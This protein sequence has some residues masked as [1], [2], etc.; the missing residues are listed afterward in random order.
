MD[1]RLP[2]KVTELI[3]QALEQEATDLFLVP[4]EPP[5]MRIDGQLQ[6]ANTPALGADEVKEMAADIL[7]EEEL[8]RIGPEL[9]E[10]HRSF[11]LPG[12]RNALF[13]VARSGGN[14]SIVVRLVAYELPTV[15]QIKLPEA[16]LEAASAR[17]GL[18]LF[19]GPVGSGKTTTMLSVL[20]HINA[21]RQ[22]HICT[23]ED[24][25]FMRLRSKQAIIQQREVGQDVPTCL[26]GIHAAMQQ[27]LDVLMVGEL[28]TVEELTACISVAETGSLVLSQLH[29]GT[30]AAAIERVMD[31]FPPDLWEISRKALARSLRAVCAQRLLPRADSQGRV[32]AYDVLVPDQVIRDAIASGRPILSDEAP[33]P[34]GC[35]RM[36][37]HIRQLEGEGVI[38]PEVAERVLADIIAGR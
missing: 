24:P 12:D 29:V 28:K 10:Q 1:T 27:D 26:S 2:K 17:S 14:Y 34:E 6:R 16:V 20:D 11:P 25:V 7:G 37:D 23:V 3:A 9:G 38:T 31:V 36:T 5:A 32:A 22:V 21:T 33:L 8:K 15:E 18:I 30:A 19:S 13:G 4:G 35:L